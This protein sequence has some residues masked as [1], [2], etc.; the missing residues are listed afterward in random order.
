[1][2]R[3]PSIGAEL[4]HPL[5]IAPNP[6]SAADLSQR[7][8]KIP[9]DAKGYGWR[10][11]DKASKPGTLKAPTKRRLCTMCTSR[12][13]RSPAK[14]Q[15]V[16]GFPHDQGAAIPSANGH[17]RQTAQNLER[18]LVKSLATWNLDTL[19]ISET[20]EFH[21]SRLPCSLAIPPF[22]HCSH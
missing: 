9:K 21:P 18:D 4:L 17:Q 22:R 6:W 1:M 10:R 8:P 2:P 11:M 7:Y 15:T 3:M 12:H 19:E 20:S 5:A 16:S 13:L 14:F